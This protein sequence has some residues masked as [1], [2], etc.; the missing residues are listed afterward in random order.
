MTQGDICIHMVSVGT[1]E[2]NNAALTSIPFD[3]SIENDTIYAKNVSNDEISCADPGHYLVGY[4][5]Y[6]RYNGSQRTFIRSAVLINNAELPGEYGSQGCAVKNTSNRTLGLN[7]CCI[8]DLAAD[9]TVS[10]GTQ[11]LA[12]AT[13]TCRQVSNQGGMWILKLSDSA[14]YFL[15]R[16]TSAQTLAN[17]SLE[18]SDLNIPLNDAIDAGFSH[19]ANSSDIVLQSAGQYLVC[20]GYRVENRSGE[21]KAYQGRL[22][23]DNMTLSES[24]S[25]GYSRYDNGTRDIVLGATC[26][27]R[28]TAADSIL[29]IQGAQESEFDGDNTPIITNIWITILKLETETP[30]LRQFLT[31]GSQEA[32]PDDRTTVDFDAPTELD[33]EFGTEAG[34][35]ITIAR[36]GHYLHTANI[37]IE[38]SATSSIRQNPRMR[39]GLNDSVFPWGGSANY[40][41]GNSSNEGTLQCCVMNS[42]LT[43][44]ASVG[45]IFDIQ[46][47]ETGD[48]GPGVN[49]IVEGGQTCLRVEDLVLP[50]APPTPPAPPQ[51]VIQI[52]NSSLIV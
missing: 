19:A 21:R 11:R 41:R 22:T 4:Q 20:Y 52:G 46:I 27:I 42:I 14:S 44:P 23:L 10:I 8:V 12:A 26:L 51:S 45:D 34:G 9:D 25:Y 36:A 49:D 35:R 30:C 39:F 48:S 32:S 1:P 15:A 24:V 2:L 28:T 3:F 47:Q 17:T 43:N 7:Q 38:K 31:A 5:L 6:G 29:R 40:N 13:D 16:G 50:P 33:S 37:R 18:F